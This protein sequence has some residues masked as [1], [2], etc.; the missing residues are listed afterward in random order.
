MWT[1]EPLGP[2]RQGEAVQDTN[3]HGTPETDSLRCRS[4][5]K[6]TATKQR[7]WPLLDKLAA[8]GQTRRL[9]SACDSGSA[10]V[11]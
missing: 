1:E 9:A 10:F 8:V 11:V 2:L 7:N 3:G 6:M 5:T 4:Q